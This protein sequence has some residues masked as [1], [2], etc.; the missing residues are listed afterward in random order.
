MTTHDLRLGLRMSDRIA[1]L[2]KGKILYD[3]RSK[4]LDITKLKRIYQRV[5]S[6]DYD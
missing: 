5:I 4:K 1:I 2:A 3:E 6:E